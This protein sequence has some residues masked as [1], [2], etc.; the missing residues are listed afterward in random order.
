MPRSLFAI[1]LFL[2]AATAMA[3]TPVAGDDGAENSVKPGKA[4][5]TVSAPDGDATVGGRRT[6]TPARSSTPHA[7]TPRWH[8]LLPGMIR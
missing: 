6:A 3:G 1:C 7:V 2:S 4:A 5:S 8:S